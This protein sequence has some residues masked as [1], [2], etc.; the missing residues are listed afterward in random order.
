MKAAEIKL[1]TTNKHTH[2][3]KVLHTLGGKVD[4]YE[5]CH[6]TDSQKGIRFVVHQPQ[7]LP[8][9]LFPAYRFDVIIEAIEQ[10]VP[11]YPSPFVPLHYFMGRVFEECQSPEGMEYCYYYE[12]KVFSTTLTTIYGLIW[13]DLEQASVFPNPFQ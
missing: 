3:K 8:A 11:A 5:N 4:I 13:A 6:I 2:M 12:E 9:G 7:N 10:Y 1:I